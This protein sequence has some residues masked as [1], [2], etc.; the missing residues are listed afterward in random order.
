MVPRPARG[1]SWRG[2]GVGRGAS[3]PG[4]GGFGRRRASPVCYPRALL[5]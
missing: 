3:G 2:A 4:A 1:G 5:T